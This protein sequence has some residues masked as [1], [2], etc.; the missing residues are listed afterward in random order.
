MSLLRMF[1]SIITS[2]LLEP[3]LLIGN[4]MPYFCF[5]RA[6]DNRIVSGVYYSVRERC[7]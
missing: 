3:Y 1:C 6:C 2:S 7:K 4:F 5:F